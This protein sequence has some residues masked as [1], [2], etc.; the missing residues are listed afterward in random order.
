MNIDPEDLTEK[1]IVF[2]QTGHH[3]IRKIKLNLKKKY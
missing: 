3:I 1:Q 2:F